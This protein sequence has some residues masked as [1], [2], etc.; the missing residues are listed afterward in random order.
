MNTERVQ[1]ALLL[2]LPLLP[3]HIGLIP[4]GTS[5]SVNTHVLTNTQRAVSQHACKHREHSPVVGQWTKRTKAFCT[6]RRCCIPGWICMHN[7]TE[8]EV[9]PRWNACSPNGCPVPNFFHFNQRTFSKFSLLFFSSS[10]FF[11]FWIFFFFVLTF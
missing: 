11:S 5:Q 1:I 8:E 9:L 7:K 6:L 4:T 10:V 3:E 2:L